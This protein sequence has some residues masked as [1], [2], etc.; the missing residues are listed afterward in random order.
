ME[1]REYKTR[2]AEGFS[3]N[4]ERD[5]Q[6]AAL[7]KKKIDYLETKIDYNNPQAM[8]RLYEKAIHDRVFKTPVGILFL[9]K[10]QGILID[11]DEINNED[12]IPIPVFYSM[13]DKIRRYQNPAQNRVLPSEQKK[14]RVNFVFL[15]VI[16]NILLVVAIMAMFSIALNTEQPNII[17]YRTTIVN[18]YSQWEQELTQREAAVREK[19]KELQWTD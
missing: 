8:L 18:Q 5:A 10:L 16:L 14:N 6:A 13:D 17:N 19:E 3:F 2:E 15:S 7:E 1:D 9:K 4:N 11:S 12:I